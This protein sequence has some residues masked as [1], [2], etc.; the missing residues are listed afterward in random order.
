[1]LATRAVDQTEKLMTLRAS[2]ILASVLWLG[3]C[4]SDTGPAPAGRN[5]PAA[6]TR[7]PGVLKHVPSVGVHLLSGEEAEVEKPAEAETESD[8]RE[9]KPAEF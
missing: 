7:T 5:P 3:A 1:M 6:P 4:A 2:W 9:E 8:P